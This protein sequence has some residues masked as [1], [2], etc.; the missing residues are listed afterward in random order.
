[1]P[2][3]NNATQQEA[4]RLAQA[5][6]NLRQQEAARLI[7]QQEAA[8][9]AQ[10]QEYRRRQEDARIAALQEQLHQDAIRSQAEV[11]SRQ[12]AA[13]LQAEENSRQEEA[14]Q[15]AQQVSERLQ[16]EAK[17]APNISGGGGGSLGQ[18]STPNLAS[19]NQQQQMP[20]AAGFSSTPSDAGATNWQQQTPQAPVVHNAPPPIDEQAAQGAFQKAF[21]GKGLM[22]LDAKDTPAFQVDVNPETARTAREDN[23]EQ[24]NIQVKEI[25]KWKKSQSR[26][27]SRRELLVEQRRGRVRT[28]KGPQQQV[29]SANFIQPNAEITK[30]AQATAFANQLKAME[31]SGKRAAKEAQHND[32]QLEP[33]AQHGPFFPPS[34]TAAS[35]ETDE[36]G[37]QLENI[38]NELRNDISQFNNLNDS[39]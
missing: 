14:N 17:A 27:K 36:F 2:S 39:V 25:E 32:E 30:Q 35:A 13:R 5:Q 15:Q 4:A 10:E 24:K 16:K 11:K 8:R 7:Q 37:N 20:P 33:N 23:K 26:S 21:G 1:M 9:L 29:S 6:E 12:E 18:G 31:E 3:N 34:T 28:T 19:A 38:T 22:D